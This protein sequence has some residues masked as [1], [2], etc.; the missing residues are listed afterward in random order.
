MRKKNEELMDRIVA[1]MDGEF[2]EDG[3]YPTIR[4]IAEAMGISKSCAANY[5][6]YMQ[7]KGLLEKK[8][9]WNGIRTKAI[10]KIS[11]ETEYVP[12]IGTVACGIPLLAEQ[13]IENYLPIPKEILGNGKHFILKAIG[14]SMINAGISDGDYVI[15]RQQDDAE[16]GKIIVALIND[17]ATL[18]R[19]YI[20]EKKKKVRLHPEN[21]EMEDMY[22]DNVIIQGVAVKIIKDIE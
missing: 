8:G 6:N 5:V 12:V 11:N 7:G 3:N 13:N 18:K 15:V 22:Y 20:D 17:E 4:Q 19:Y 16:E 21:D 10:N 14:N 1:Y 9:G 2:M